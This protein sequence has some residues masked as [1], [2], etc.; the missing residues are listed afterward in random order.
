MSFDDR[1]EFQALAELEQ[2]L[3]NLRDGIADWRR[4]ALRAEGERAGIE[5]GADVVGLQQRLLS[6]EAENAD[7][8]RRLDA[9]RERLN[10]LLSRLRFLEEQVAL[11]EQR[12]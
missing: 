8:H 5:A 3:A 12:S 4:R 7:L 1:P 10:N 6:V 2:V 11:E 9:A